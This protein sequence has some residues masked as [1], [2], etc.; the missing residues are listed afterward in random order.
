MTL[1]PSALPPAPSCP[2]NSHYRTCVPPCSPT[3]EH[4]NGP[5]GCTHNK[6]CERGCVCDD[7]F[8]NTWR[9]CV[10]VQ[11]CGC[12]DRNGIGRD[13]SVKITQVKHSSLLSEGLVIMMHADV[14]VLAFREVWYTEH[15]SQ[16]CECEK[17]RGEGRID[18]DDKDECDGNAVCLQNVES[19]YYCQPTGFSE[20]SIRGDPEYRTFD[21]MRHDFDGE[22]SYVLVRTDGLPDYLPHVYIEAINDDDDG[23]DDD[24]SHHHGDSSSEEHRRRRGSDEDEDENEEDDDSDSHQHRHSSEEE[25]RDHRGLRELKIR[26]YNHTVVFRKHRRLVVSIQS[27]RTTLCL[28]LFLQRILSADKLFCSWDYILIFS[29]QQ[30]FVNNNQ[31]SF[32]FIL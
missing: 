18:C 25:D 28:P 27:G 9:G 32:T 23:D 24:D 16:K 17:R 26:V 6:R 3:C 20:C 7:G 10:P 14:D 11:R 15:C 12:V 5:P 4:L 21:R 2:A 30:T 22:H 1:L 31:R 8:V 13:V 29:L 19:Y